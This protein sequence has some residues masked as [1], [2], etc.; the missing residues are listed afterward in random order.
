V[1]VASN[2]ALG[3]GKAPMLPIDGKA[4]LNDAVKNWLARSSA[5]IGTVLIVDSTGAIPS[6]VDKQIGDLIS[7]P[8][9]FTTTTNPTAPPLN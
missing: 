3:N 5:A 7:G 1:L 2:L 6:D 8:L 9:G 4:G